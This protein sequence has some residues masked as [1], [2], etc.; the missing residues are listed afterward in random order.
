MQTCEYDGELV[1][2][3]RSH[4]W[5]DASGHP[6][7]RY[8]DLTREPGQI[9]TVL[10]DYV[11]WNRYPA[12]EKFYTLIAGINQPEFALESNDCEFTGPE[13]NPSTTVPKRMMC[14]GRVMIFFRNLELNIHPDKIMGLRLQLH[15]ALEAEDPDFCCGVVGTTIVPV[16]YLTVRGGTVGTQLMIS[17]WAWGDTESENMD[18]L[19]RVFTNLSTAMGVG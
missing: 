7:F 6:E 16:R 13:T 19:G 8:Y 3:V 17:Y 5:T 11:P 15:L 18:N 1:T 2:E 9:R 14:S 12:V 10:E 4:P